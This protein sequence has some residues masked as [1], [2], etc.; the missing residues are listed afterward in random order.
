[1]LSCWRLTPTLCLSTRHRSGFY[2]R[3]ASVQ[4]PV[5]GDQ[6]NNG[7]EKKKKIAIVGSGWAGLGAAH[8]LCKQGFDVKV[9]DDGNGFGSPDDVCIQGFWYPYQNIF[10]FVDELGIEPFTDWMKSVLYSEGG[11]EVEFPIFQDLP[12]LPTPLGTLFYTQ[13]NRVPLVDRLTSLALMAAVIDF[14]NTDVAWKNYDSITA[15]EL[16]KQF[17]CSERLYR[18]VI[19]PLL[20]V[21]LFAPAEQCS[22][23]ATLGI[24]YYFILAHQKNFDLVWC[25][26]TLNEKI[27]EPWMDLMRTR[28]CEFLDGRKVTDFVLNEETGCISEVV[29]GKEKY[30]ADAVILA[31]GISTLQELV[32]NSA[33]LCTQEEFLKVLNLSCI[34]VISVKLRFDKKVNIPNAS[35]ACSGFSDSFAWTFFDLNQIYD[36]HKDDPVTVLQADFYHANELLP[37]KDE[38]VIAKVMS[39]L[40]KCIKEFDTAT[41]TDKQIRRFPKS[42]TH[43]FPGSYKYMMRGSTSFPNLFMAGDWITTRHGSWSQEKSFVTGLEAA[44]RVVDYLEDGSFAK[45]IP[46][47]EDEAHIETFRNL[48]RRFNE[49]REQVPLSNYFLQ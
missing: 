33:S 4:S 8:H 48:N 18:D 42:L 13:F 5:N 6:N 45:I 41:V 19:G 28:D 11:L 37:L 43:Y 16:F 23:A 1:M 24:L 20:Q 30:N 25:R 40:S 9:V 36:E 31:V 15:R 35:N 38:Q 44:N 12:Q 3:T 21:G 22:A 7:E 47:E 14:D 49:I 27:F 32:K 34:G 2:C 17:G 46:V 26:G 29:C 10:S 39:C